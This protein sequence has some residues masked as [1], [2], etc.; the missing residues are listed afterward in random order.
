M[1]GR[2]WSSLLILILNCA[3]VLSSSGISD[4]AITTA[5]LIPKVIGPSMDGH[6]P[7][8]VVSHT[9]LNPV[10]AEVTF[11]PFAY[12]SG[13]PF[14]PPSS[15][16]TMA[17]SEVLSSDTDAPFESPMTEAPSV[18]SPTGTNPPVEFPSSTFRPFSYPT[19]SPFV[20][21][22][23]LATVAPVEVSPTDTNAP[24]EVSSSTPTT[25]VPS[26]VLP[27]VTNVPVELPFS[28]PTTVAP[29]EV[30]PSGTNVP[31]YLPPAAPSSTAA[32]F[33]VSRN[34]T[35]A[36]AVQSPSRPTRK[37]FRAIRLLVSFFITH[38]QANA[39]TDEILQIIANSVLVTT[40]P[41]PS[42]VTLVE[43][44]CNTCEDSRRSLVT[45]RCLRDNCE[46]GC[47]TGD[48]NNPEEGCKTEH[49]GER[50]QP[51]YHNYTITGY[52]DYFIFGRN[53]KERSV[54]DEVKAAL[55]N[56][57]ESGQLTDE[58]QNEADQAG[59]S[60]CASS[61]VVTVTVNCLTCD[62]IAHGIINAFTR[63]RI[64]GICIGGVV[65]TSVIFAFVAFFYKRR[66]TYHAP[67]N[68]ED[69]VTN[70]DVENLAVAPSV[71]V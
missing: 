33:S 42:L 20:P 44:T 35:V 64:V 11:A 55:V 36:P 67:G 24:F 70:S 59:A 29:S 30:S 61:Q 60:A 40:F 5:G 38:I 50:F 10:K 9:G 49:C 52:C 12:P 46:G 37:K 17:P 6:A 63:G 57:V 4:E 54:V 2:P 47:V 19:A 39:C 1:I 53:V 23:S 45:T 41:T 27:S 15:L 62:A 13:A 21:P 34:P 25:R 58:I 43:S 8:K 26:V 56:A 69:E 65:F 16:G 3:V 31:F 51:V 71:N 32:P 48:G 14:I 28:T 68:S 18:V 7:R 66:N 22:S